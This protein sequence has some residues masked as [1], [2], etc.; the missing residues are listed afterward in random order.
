[1]PTL[2]KRLG[3][4]SFSYSSRDRE[5]CEP[6]IIGRTG[7]IICEPL[8]SIRNDLP[9]VES[10]TARPVRLTGLADVCQ[11]RVF[12]AERQRLLKKH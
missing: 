7:Y 6:G 9:L 10:T 4:R 3:V 1:M 2:S 5:Y 12:D 8:D 11:N